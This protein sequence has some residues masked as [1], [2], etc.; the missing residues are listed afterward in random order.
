MF[1]PLDKKPDWHHPPLVTLILVLANVLLFYTW[2]SNDERYDQEAFEYYLKSGLIQTELKAYLIDKRQTER[3]SRQ[4]LEH[5]THTAM[6]VFDEMRR[7]GNFQRRLA[8]GL[9]I[10]PSDIGY[11]DW[12]TQHEHFIRLKQRVVA[13][14][15][16]LNPYQP[17]VLTFMTNLFLHGNNGHLFGNMVMLLLLGF[18]VEIILGRW[19]F[20]LGYLICGLAAG[21][22]YVLLNSGETVTTIGASGAIA[23]ILGMSVMIYGLRKIN[24]FYFLFIYFDYVKARAIWIIPLYILSQIII[25]FVF[26]TNV[27]VAA[28]LGGFF[29]GIAY[30]AALKLIPNAFNAEQV[31]ESQRAELYRQSIQSAQQLIAA[32]KNDE[33]REVLVQLQQAFPNDLTVMRLRFTIAKFKPASDEYHELAH[34]LLNLP[35]SDKVTVK[36][37]Y[38]TFTDYAAKAKPNPRW[39]PELMISLA[40][41]FAANGY[42]D[43]AEKLVNHMISTMQEFPRNAEGL[44]AL[45]KYFNGKDKQKAQHYRDLLNQLFPESMQ[46]RHLNQSAI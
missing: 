7:D 23:G 27:N 46:A 17:S 42:L 36:I 31:D 18:G 5:G 3:L 8:Q 29:A 32:M 19:L 33:A 44:F 38:D 25:E 43:E 40:T 41:R 20:L 9:V 30:V 2:Q 37:V 14:K 45:A 35:G 10:K 11:T 13:E 12:L 39:T 6:V 1:L 15:Y 26:D 24:F 34:Q 28:H 21:L 16:G 22:T 4:D